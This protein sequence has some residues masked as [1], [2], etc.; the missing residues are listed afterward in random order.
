L[1]QIEW[2]LCL[3]S[4]SFVFTFFFGRVRAG[5]LRTFHS[6]KSPRKSKTCKKDSGWTFSLPT[7]FSLFVFL[8]D[9]QKRLLI[10]KINGMYDDDRLVSD[11]RESD[12][13]CRSREEEHKPGAMASVRRA[14]GEPA[15][16]WDPRCVLPSR[17]Q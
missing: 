7:V 16:G 1:D 8:G 3:S 10:E 4:F 13:W 11:Q 2:I 9:K 14:A 6:S 17:P 12:T 15:A 5:F